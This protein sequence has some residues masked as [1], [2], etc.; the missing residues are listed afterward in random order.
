MGKGGGTH[1]YRDGNILLFQSDYNIIEIMFQKPT[2]ANYG[3]YK[4]TD[5]DRTLAVKSRKTTEK[6]VFL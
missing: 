2:I 6:S 1:Y 3:H 5:R 4:N